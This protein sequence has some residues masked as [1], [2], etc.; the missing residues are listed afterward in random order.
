[1][2]QGAFPEGEVRDFLGVR[3][4]QISTGFISN[5]L[6]LSAQFSK[7]SGPLFALSV[8]WEEFVLLCRAGK[9]QR[10]PFLRDR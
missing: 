5:M 7:L 10:I 6:C 3:T 8:M 1:M 4:R 2:S 9:A